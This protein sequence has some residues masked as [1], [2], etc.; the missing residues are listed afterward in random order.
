[1]HRHVPVTTLV[2]CLGLAAAALGILTGIPQ[3][4]RLLRTP[5]AS[6]L[7]YS[8]AILGVLSSGT[9]LTYGFALLDPRSWSPTSRAWAARSSPWCSPPAGWAWP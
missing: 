8:S 4:V 9:W 2:S 1:M 3:V 7:S 6:G 5:D